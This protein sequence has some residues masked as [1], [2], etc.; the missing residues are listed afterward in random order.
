MERLEPE[1]SHRVFVSLSL[2]GRALRSFANSFNNTKIWQASE[3]TSEHYSEWAHLAPD[4]S[5]RKGM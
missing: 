4:F 1:Q 5:G 2:F 3:R